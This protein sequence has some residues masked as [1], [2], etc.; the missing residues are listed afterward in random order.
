MTKKKFDINEIKKICLLL[1][2]HEK[3]M[4]KMII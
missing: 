1:E 2:L 4:N 3:E